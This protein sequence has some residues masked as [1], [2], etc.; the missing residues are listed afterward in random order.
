MNTFVL[1]GSAL[2]LALAPATVVAQDE[3]AAETMP[4]V[5]TSAEDATAADPR[6]AALPADKQAQLLAWPEATQEYYWSLTVERQDLF[7]LLADE[8]KVRLSQ[9]PEEQQAA[10]WAQIES[11]P[12]PS[13]G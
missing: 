3:V 2:G 7:W 1:S 13:Q 6:L 4:E 10:A 11:R 5:A 8:D 9:L 12:R